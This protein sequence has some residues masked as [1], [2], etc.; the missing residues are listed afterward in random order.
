MYALYVVCVHS[1]RAYVQHVDHMCGMCMCS[2]YIM[3]IVCEYTLCA[4]CIYIYISCACLYN[5]YTVLCNVYIPC[6]YSMYV[7]VYIVHVYIVFI[8]YAQYIAVCVRTV[9]NV[10]SV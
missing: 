9:Y 10:Y 5:V 8:A 1:M 2:V 7:H 6:I 3:C 4:V